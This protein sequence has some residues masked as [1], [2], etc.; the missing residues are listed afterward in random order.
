MLLRL[1]F[2]LSLCSVYGFGQTITIFGDVVDAEGDPAFN[3]SYYFKK[4]PEKKF[5]T[6][7]DGKFSIQYKVGEDDSLIFKSVAFDPYQ[8]YISKKLEKKA[9]RNDDSLYFRIAMPDRSL[10]L[11][12][13]KPN[14]PD[15]ICGFIEFSIED[16]ELLDNG[17]MIL[18]T[19]EKTLKK[20]AVLRL[21]DENLN[22]LDRH[23]VAGD[24][25]ELK[26]DFR[27]NIHLICE[28][29]VYLVYLQD[30]EVRCGLENRD[31]Y[32]KYVAPILDTIG[33]N[34]Y[35][36]NYSEIYPA[37]DYYEFNRDDSVYNVLLKV[38][39]T[40]MMELYRS[41][42]K[43]V[44]VRTKLWAHQKQI[45]TG[46]DKEIWVGATVFTNSIYYQPL[47][48]PL[49]KTEEDIILVFDHYKNKLFRY[50]PTE[51][52]I[53]STRISYH[54]DQRRS[55]WE[56][57]LLQDEKQGH[58]YAMF[59]K[60]G[61]TYLSEIDQQNGHVRKSFKLFYKYVEKIR[62]ID[63]YVYYIYRPFESIQKKYVYRE[64]LS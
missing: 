56:Q 16:F 2:I 47:Y 19:Y 33:P 25:I 46:I 14:T 63:G 3:V 20:G 6:D 29:R 26:K 40:L 32:F 22:E 27:D 45:E 31:Y 41:E 11:I 9:Q 15:T 12:E 5:K 43:Y 52:F 23:Y 55:G 30:N 60:G 18:L 4:H 39:D 7:R 34:L 42:Y 28:E 54:L 17:W 44:D 1:L 61:Y 51:G 24:A 8:L 10:N 48:A 62:I 13:I 53:D 59:L 64:K 58:V 35:F 36:S 37:F 21:F 50:K 57:P 49:F 38:E